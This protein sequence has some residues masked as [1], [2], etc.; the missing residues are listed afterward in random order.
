M[1]HYAKNGVI[2][3]LTSEDLE[4]LNNNPVNRVLKWILLFT[5]LCCFIL[6]GWATGYTYDHAPPIP[7]KI[8]SIDNHTIITQDD[9]YLGKQGFQR[10]DLIDYGSLY[11]MGSMF[12][13]D[14]TA[15][16]LVELANATQN[17]LAQE[18]FNN[19]YEKLPE[20]QQFRIQKQM[21]SMLHGVDLTQQDVKI[22][23][24]FAKAIADVREQLSQQLLKDDPKA[25]Y[26][27][28][29][30]LDAV[31]AKNTSDFIIYTALTS[32]G[33]R[34]NSNISWTQNWPYEP[35][36]GNVPTSET[37]IWTW[38]GICFAFAGFGFVI[39]INKLWLSGEDKGAMDQVIAGFNGLTPSQ[40]KV[41]KYFI[42][43]GCIFLIQILMGGLMAH[44]YSERADFY[45]FPIGEY[46]PFNFL[47]SIHLQTPIVWIAFS[48][49]GAGLFLGPIVSGKEAKFQG[50]LVDIL[51]YASVVVIAGIVVGNYFSLMGYMPKLWFWL[52]NQGNS[53]LEL[54]RD[55]QYAFFGALLLW[56]YLVFRAFWP[57]KH[58]WQEARRSFFVGKIRLEH[59][60]WIS[61]VNIALLY[62][63]GM[64]PMF[65]VGKSYTMDD[66]WRWWVVHLWVE[67]SFEFFAACVTAYLLMGI[68]LV[69]RQLAE[70]TVYFELILIFLGGVIGTG[71]HM[72]WA[73]EPSI[74]IPMGSM[75]SFIEVLPLV[76]LVIESV[77]QY[78]I[79]NQHNEFQYKLAYMFIIAAAVWNFVGAGIFGGG[80]LNAPL[81]NYYEHGTSL[82][83]NHAHTAMFGAFGLLGLGMIYFCL[84]YAAG[85]KY[86]F[87]ER[88]GYI[89]LFLFNIALVLWTWLTFFPVGWPQL[90]AVYE[91]GLNFARSLSFYDTKTL[92]QWMRMFGD[93]LFACGALIM[94]FDFLVKL[95]PFFIRN[96]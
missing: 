86:P 96:R 68:G 29:R 61:T 23:P 47:R 25:G 84:R 63:C 60:F 38:V 81:A 2:S 54:G 57:N 22:A 76:L 1:K 49:I 75:F 6:M 77:D 33:H 10:A 64:I 90:N 52:G 56:S 14:Y 44:Y 94:V 39:L 42:F 19:S 18:Q 11:G 80:V 74:W 69:S 65:E 78:R 46:L 48:W 59:L 89:A 5:A 91:H 17:Y 16:A 50:V 32:V 73:G 35:I 8:S 88:W 27:R 7:Q 12:G 20:D 30:S 66:F 4:R 72:Y 26:S 71:H 62:V 40:R 34:P 53:Y 55:W 85:N 51:F 87:I 67:E 70:R 15:L 93:I 28:A 95:K 43:V 21:Q 13:P 24:P 45:G 79:I 82:T 9:I 31:G 41:G 36:V 58:I 37:F 83:L 92:W 3:H